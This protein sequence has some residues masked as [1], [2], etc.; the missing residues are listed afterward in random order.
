MKQALFALFTLV[1]VSLGQQSVLV[2]ADQMEYEKDTIVYTGKV[3][4]VHGAGVLTADKV[5]IYLGEDKKVK[6]LEAIGN[7]VYTENIKKARAERGEY[8]LNTK[9][10]RLIGNARIEEGPNF[11][12]ADEIIY[13]GREK[14]ALAV[15]K[16][17][18]VRSFYVEEKNEKVGNNR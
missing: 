10:L 5:I 13:Y 14:R 8:D 4:A 6:K 16:G 18:R 12:E 17:R 11:V 7:V 15:S 3:K 1:Y 9:V 2:E